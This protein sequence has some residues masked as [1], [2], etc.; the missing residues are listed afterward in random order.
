[1][2][3]FDKTSRFFYFRKNIGIPSQSSPRCR[4]NQHSSMGWIDTDQ[5]DII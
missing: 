4:E 5:F 2:K 3:D 1:M